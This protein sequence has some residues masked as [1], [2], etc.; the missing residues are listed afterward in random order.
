MPIKYGW[1][2]HVIVYNCTPENG[3]ADLKDAESAH[4]LLRATTSSEPA[5]AHAAAVRGDVT[6]DE[7]SIVNL[8]AVLIA[9]SAFGDQKYFREGLQ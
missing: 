8:L 4:C 7:T 3:C 2:L 1:V 6:H 5:C 9:G